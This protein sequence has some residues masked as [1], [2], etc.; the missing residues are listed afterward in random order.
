MKVRVGLLIILMSFNSNVFSGTGSSRPSRKSHERPLLGRD[1]REVLVV[2]V[3]REKVTIEELADNLTY[4]LEDG[5]CG[6]YSVESDTLS[7][8]KSAASSATTV[9]LFGRDKINIFADESGNLQ[10]ELK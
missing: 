9:K 10:Y 1:I 7:F 2:N 6:T 8:R 5:K 3:S 4:S